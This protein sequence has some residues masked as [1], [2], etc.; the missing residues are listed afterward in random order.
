MMVAI[1]ETGH[2]DM[3]AVAEDLVRPVAAGEI[4]CGANLDDLAVAL[5]DCAVFDDLSPIVID[6]P[7]NYVLAANQRR[8]HALRLFLPWPERHAEIARLTSDPVS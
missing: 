3:T 1:D 2:D 6:D 4:L 5:K 8:R 7:A